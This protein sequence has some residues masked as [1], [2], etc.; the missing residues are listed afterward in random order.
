MLGVHLAA[1]TCK[2]I[3]MSERSDDHTDAIATREAQRS[4]QE[5]RRNDR[6]AADR[7]PA[8]VRTLDDDSVDGNRDARLAES[9]PTPGS[10]EGERDPARQSDS[11]VPRE[12]DDRH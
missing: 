11:N 2:E 10:A 4:D 1:T 12:D 6:K 7:Q 8:D 9:R 5:Q 3:A